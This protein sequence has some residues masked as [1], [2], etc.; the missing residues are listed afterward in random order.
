ML[1]GANGRGLDR[2]L[3]FRKWLNGA[4]ETE[5]KEQV[6]GSLVRRESKRK[7][8]SGCSHQMIYLRISLLRSF[9]L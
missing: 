2:L 6:D 5:E 8:N 3:V 1:D 7:E 9:C 4:Y